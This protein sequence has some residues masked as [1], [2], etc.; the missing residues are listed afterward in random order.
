MKSMT[1]WKQFSDIHMN[2]QV[3]TQILRTTTKKIQSLAKGMSQTS[4][5]PTEGRT[6]GLLNRLHATIFGRLAGAFATRYT[7]EDHMLL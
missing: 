4:H 5:L 1:L 2:F 3:S 7:N 6:N